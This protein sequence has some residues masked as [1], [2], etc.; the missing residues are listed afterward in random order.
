MQLA[1]RQCQYPQPAQVARH[2][3]QSM[4]SQASVACTSNPAAGKVE[5]RRTSRSIVSIVA[6]GDHVVSPKGLS[7]KAKESGGMDRD[8]HESDLKEGTSLYV[9]FVR[10]SPKCSM[11]QGYQ[12]SDWTM[13]VQATKVPSMHN[14]HGR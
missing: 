14:E 2:A 13:S 9:L 4:K 3:I 11:L 6:V 7:R 8:K 12:V 10:Q 1:S 5:T